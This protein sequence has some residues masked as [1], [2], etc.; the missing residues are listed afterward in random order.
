MITVLGDAPGSVTQLFPAASASTRRPSSANLRR[1]AITC[2][3]LI[4]DFCSLIEDI[5]TVS[6]RAYG[7]ARAPAL[8]QRR[9]LVVQSAR[10]LRAPC[11]TVRP[12]SEEHHAKDLAV[13]ARAR[14]RR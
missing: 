4:L 14:R 2:C 11:P 9:A 6:G 7:P 10:F 12:N 3:A 13:D 8:R 1:S 5:S